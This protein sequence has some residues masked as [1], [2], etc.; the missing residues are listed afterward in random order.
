MWKS[1]QLLEI[2]VCVVLVSES[3]EI[4]VCVLLVSESEET[5]SHVNWSSIFITK[6]CFENDLKA[7]PFKYQSSI[8]TPIDTV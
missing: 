4:L 8:D 6:I 2:L 3:E 1:S 7:Q 5:H